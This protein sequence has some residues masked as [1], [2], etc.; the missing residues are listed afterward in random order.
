MLLTLLLTF[1]SKSV[2][3]A[4]MDRIP[5]ALTIA[6]I[7]KTWSTQTNNQ[8]NNHTNRDVLLLLVEVKS[9]KL[10]T[11][12]FTTYLFF[13]KSICTLFCYLIYSF[14]LF[15]LD[16]YTLAKRNLFLQMKSIMNCPSNCWSIRNGIKGRVHLKKKKWKFFHSEQGPTPPKSGKKYF[17]LFDI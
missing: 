5:A 14:I 4:L 17:L 1:S 8:F 9:T 10:C 15:Y 2:S 11:K 12:S 3:S 7:N 13:L 6:W 16:W